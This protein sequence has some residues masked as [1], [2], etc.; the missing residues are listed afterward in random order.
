MKKRVLTVLALSLLI[1][2]IAS[3]GPTT[4][5]VSSPFHIFS[6]SCGTKGC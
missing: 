6:I 4:L 3:A 5:Q 1:G 2:S